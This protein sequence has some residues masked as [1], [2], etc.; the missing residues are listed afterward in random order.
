M[1]PT[2]YIQE[3]Q[4]LCP[5]FSILPPS[6]LVRLCA[7][8][9]G[10]E[11]GGLGTEEGGREAGHSGRGSSNSVNGGVRQCSHPMT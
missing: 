10:G 3:P 4:P 5:T 1:Y 8:E 11:G 7:V 9:D 6:G 2:P